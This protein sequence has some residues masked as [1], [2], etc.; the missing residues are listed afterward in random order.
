LLL[1]TD[2]TLVHNPALLFQSFLPFYCW[3]LQCQLS[4]N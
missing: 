4:F 1:L 2:T 3:C